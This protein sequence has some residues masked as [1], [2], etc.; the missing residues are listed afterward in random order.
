LELGDDERESGDEGRERDCRLGDR[1]E[2]DFAAHESG[3]DDQRRNEL[4]EPIIPG[5]EK[6]NVTVDRSDAPE[7]LGESIEAL[8][9]S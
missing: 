1:A 2:F 4:N 8:L 9:K 5:R 6:P 3:S 7:I